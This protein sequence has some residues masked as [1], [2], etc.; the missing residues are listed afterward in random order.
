MGT[1]VVVVGTVV[2]VVSIVV[3]VVSTVVVVAVKQISFSFLRNL[4]HEPSCWV[5]SKSQMLQSVSPEVQSVQSV[6][7]VLHSLKRKQECLKVE[8]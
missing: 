3:V 5:S 6:E 4:Q 1:A 8:F 7:K 2:V